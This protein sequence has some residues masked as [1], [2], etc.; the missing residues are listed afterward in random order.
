MSAMIH[1]RPMTPADISLGLR[2]SEQADWNQTE[3]D[4]RR[5]LDLEADGC[6]V[7]EWAGQPA[8]TTATFVFG[9][10]AWIAMVLVEESVRARGIGTALL[11]HALEFL[12]NRGVTSV[13]LDATPQGRPLYERLGFVEQFSLARY[14]GTPALVSQVT[15]VETAS[16]HHWPALAAL[17]QA[18]TC[19]D[20]CRLLKRL[21]AEQPE[22]VRVVLQ[23]SQPAGFMGERQGRRAVQFGPCIAAPDAGPLLL[24]D[25]LRRHVGRR[26]FLDIPLP[27]NPAALLAKARGLTVQRHLTRMCR[28]TPL[29]EKLDWLWASSGPEK[30]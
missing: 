25:A 28:G 19:T 26:V 2:F 14:E 6:F 15:G 22:A 27:N 3:A 8:G 16:A 12:D 10:V 4:W 23:G 29:C 17:D 9:P 24:E 21:F 7:A 13:R 20:R 5:F 30:G 18:A 11:G 1:I